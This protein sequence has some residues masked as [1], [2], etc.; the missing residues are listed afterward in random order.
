MAFNAF[1]THP[2]GLE[3]GG[4]WAPMWTENRT[5]EG[6]VT[7]GWSQAPLLWSLVFGVSVAFPLVLNEVLVILSPTEIRCACMTGAL[8]SL[9]PKLPTF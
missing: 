7:L 5:L 8:N 4:S 9:R 6:T 1:H 3:V 2:L